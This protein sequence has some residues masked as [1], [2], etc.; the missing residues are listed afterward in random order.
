MNN[1]ISFDTVRVYWN[2]H[3]GCY[4]V[5]SFIKG[6]GWRVVSH[7]DK[8]WLDHPEFVVSAAGQARVRREGRK[9]VHAYIIGAPGEF[10]VGDWWQCHE[11][12]DEESDAVTYD[13]YRDDTFVLR[14]GR[15]SI[16]SAH[17]AL[18]MTDPQGRPSVRVRRPWGVMMNAA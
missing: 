4:S 9:Q 11:D 1:N 12:F 3:K 8:L 10:T 17:E 15:R 6:K 16:Q 13:P 5:Q 14:E 18:L 7:V 2:L